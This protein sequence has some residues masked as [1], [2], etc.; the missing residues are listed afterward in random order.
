[1]A[2]DPT[3]ISTATSSRTSSATASP[4]I[5]LSVFDDDEF[6]LADD[7][8]SLLPRWNSESSIK[9][10]GQGREWLERLAG[11]RFKLILL[12]A[13]ATG[14]IL[15]MLLDDNLTRTL[16]SSVTD[17]LTAL[18]FDSDPALTPG[19]RTPNASLPLDASAAPPALPLSHTQLWLLNQTTDSN[20]GAIPFAPEMYTA[21][22]PFRALEAPSTVLA[23]PG[24]ADAW[25]ARRE[26]CAALRGRWARPEDKPQLDVVW[27]WVNGS[28]NEFL[29]PWRAKVSSEIGEGLVH[30]STRS[31]GG[32][33]AKHFRDHDELRYSIRSVVTAFPT[34]ALRKLHLLVG[35]AAAGDAR[36]SAEVGT[37]E[38]RLAQ[39]PHWLSLSEATFARPSHDVLAM[40]AS[41]R[42][43]EAEL[44]IV[45]HSSIFKTSGKAGPMDRSAK[46]A[47]AA[48]WRTKVVPSFNS[49]AIEAQTANV[50]DLGE[51]FVGMND[52]FFVLKPMSASDF[53]S[54]LTGPVF[55]FQRDLMVS[56][57][58]P[59]DTLDDGDGEWRGLGFANYLLSRRFG[60]RQRPYLVHQAKA[61]SGPLFREM[62]RV[63]TKELTQSAQARFRGKQFLEAQTW[64]LFTHYV[65]EKHREALLWSWVIA[66]A[67]ADHDGFLQ[68]AERAAMLR[69]LGFKQGEETIKVWAAKR[70][71]LDRLGDSMRDAGLDEPSGT[72][73]VFSSQ[74]GYAHFR[75]LAQIQ[76]NEFRPWPA[77]EAGQDTAELPACE[78]DVAQCFGPDFLSAEP[79]SDG[80]TNAYVALKRLAFEHPQCGDCVVIGLLAKSGTRGLEAFLPP[81]ATAAR[82][83][84]DPKSVPA[85]VA[86]G[87]N[88]GA[89]AGAA[90]A[91]PPLSAGMA[92][93]T[94]VRLIS[95]YAYA[96]GE[97]DSRFVSDKG[98]EASLRRMLDNVDADEPTFLALNE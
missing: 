43:A 52:D 46:E 23:E 6:H 15:F 91:G 62:H 51:A 96:V 79:P 94:A 7:T 3:P 17:Q 37:Y 57:K 98:S 13:L 90:F 16:T 25:V 56:A 85:A 64:F 21:A 18:G 9:E 26:L 75:T 31:L 77:F 80:E 34:H 42:Q 65:I 27:T 41:L 38:L 63:W 76:A 86:V 97:T 89:W 40:P 14:T 61:G 68:V 2:P 12:L 87:L 49:L 24:C 11:L 78:I 53:H 19:P 95:R 1:M 81:P 92:R 82:P 60:D 29:T 83:A 55:R 72:S 22:I 70:D 74:D 58:A 5:A 28:Q 8:D 48:L 67:D 84:V 59:T 35:D 54:P 32:A 10:A 93:L 66:R 44:Q 71:S 69:E 33:V 39:V 4:V 73:V 20:M 36:P 88:S 47:A 50:G 45:P 30:R